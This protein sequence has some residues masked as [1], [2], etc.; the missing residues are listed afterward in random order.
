M[1][2]TIRNYETLYIIDSNLMDE[3]IDGIISKYTTLI[4]EQGGE[5]Q[6]AGRWDRRR[7]AY[8]IKGRR[9]GLYILMY[10]T[11]EA[12]VKN[13][14]DR[15]FRISDELIRHIILRIEPE[16]VDITRIMQAAPAAAP[17]QEEA[18]VEA[19]PAE[20]VEVTEAPAQEEA[21]VEAAQAEEAAEAPVEAAPAEEVEVTEAPAQEKAPVEAAP[22]EETAEAPAQEKAPVEAAPAEETAEARPKRAPRKKTKSGDGDL[23]T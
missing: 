7:L 9:E 5:V 2:T 14:L 10:F 4:T 19:A 22:A 17:A 1:N 23:A 20:E 8:E 18:P 3:Q 16:S 11:G 13:E 21:P 6:A 12:A 15:M